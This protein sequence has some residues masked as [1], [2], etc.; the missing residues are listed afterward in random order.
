M[1]SPAP[2]SQTYIHG[3]LKFVSNNFVA[4][5]NKTDVPEAFH[6]VQDFLASSPIG[7]ALTSPGHISSKSVHYV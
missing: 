5:L 1:D 3:D 7:Y 4:I 6:M 2:V